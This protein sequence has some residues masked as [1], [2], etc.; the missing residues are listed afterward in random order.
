MT[1]T[2]KKKNRSYLWFFLALLFLSIAATVILVVF[3][4]QQQLKPEQLLAA[5]KLWDENGPRN[6]TM[7]Y[8]I[9]KND[10]AQE[11]V[12]WVQVRNKKVVASKYNDEP[13][14]AERR[15]YRDMDH[16]FDFVE[17]FQEMDAEKGQ[18]KVF[19]RG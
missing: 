4:L 6:Y 10:D 13:E 19:V 12:F 16:L 2:Q 7:T 14:E 17:K 8:R 18:P 3:N 11:D 9:K 15:H 5:R 1:T